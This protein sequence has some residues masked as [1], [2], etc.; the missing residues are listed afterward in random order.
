[1][2]RLSDQSAVRMLRGGIRVMQETEARTARGTMYTI[3]VQRHV[4]GTKPCYVVKAA[5]ND[6]R[7][8][9]EKT[10]TVLGNAAMVAELFQAGVFDTQIPVADLPGDLQKRL[11]R[12]WMNSTKS[13][14]PRM[15][16]VGTPGCDC[17]PHRT[18]LWD[19]HKQRVFE[20][21]HCNSE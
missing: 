17:R 4:S 19:P 10:L 13:G 5:S 1:M 12:A 14:C 7:L 11:G 21:L 18:A 16:V 8:L 3:Q 9:A 6:G 15:H 20:G 2:Q